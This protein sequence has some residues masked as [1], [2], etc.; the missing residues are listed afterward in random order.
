[1]PHLLQPRSEGVL[2][3]ARDFVAHE[4]PDVVNF[5]PFVLQRQKGPNLEVASGNVNRLGELAPVVKVPQNL[6]VVLAVVYDKEF[7]TS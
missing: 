5:L 2:R 7:A 6:P 3:A 4:Y 1:L